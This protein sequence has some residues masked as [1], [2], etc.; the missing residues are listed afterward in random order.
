MRT[1]Q[2]RVADFA[3]KSFESEV[4]CHHRVEAEPDISRGDP[5]RP[6][7]GRKSLTLA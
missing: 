6:V 5:L 7:P 3:M 4:V 2:Q 1:D